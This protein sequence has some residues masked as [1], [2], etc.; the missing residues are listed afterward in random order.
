[1]DSM[2]A[3]IFHGPGN[4][5]VEERPI[6]EIGPDEV[7]LKV[8]ATSVCASD[9]RVYR[10]EKKAVQG[11]ITGH[12]FA[13]RVAKVGEDV[14]GIAVGDRTIVCPIIACGACY[15]CQIGRRNRCL[16]RVT[17]GYDVDGGFADYVRVPSSIVRLGH[18][19]PLDSELPYDLASI[20]E[21]MACALNSVLYS[22][23][24]RAAS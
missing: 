4:I 17:L 21:P 1:M 13:G 19:I 9:I 6:P 5:K 16:K 12:E 18:M 24:P 8:G 2:R 10:G 7:L 22:E 15:Y 3:L 23:F 20:T 11:V 14:A